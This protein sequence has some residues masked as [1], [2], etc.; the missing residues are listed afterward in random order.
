MK[1]KVF[2]FGFILLICFIVIIFWG[3]YQEEDSF[4]H[5]IFFTY[6]KEK[7]IDHIMIQDEL[8][9]LDISKKVYRVLRKMELVESSENDNPYVISG[10]IPMSIYYVNNDESNEVCL[11]SG[12]IKINGTFFDI[13]NENKSSE[14]TFIQQIRNIMDS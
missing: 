7:E 1:R 6:Q 2:L 9:S 12:K 14:E 5:N 11:F 13:I 10:G 3:K 4:Q 8:I